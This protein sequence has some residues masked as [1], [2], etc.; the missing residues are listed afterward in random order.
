MPVALNIVGQ[1][2]GRLVA[3]KPMFVKGKGRWQCK[4]DCGNE[5]IVYVGLLRT[6]H[7]ESCGCLCKER[8]G[9]HSSVLTEKTTTVVGNLINHSGNSSSSARAASI[10]AIT[11]A[12]RFWTKVCL[13]KSGCWLWL[14]TKTRGYGMLS[15]QHRSSPVFAHRVS[16]VLH[17]GED[18]RGKLVHPEHLYIGNEADNS[19][20]AWKR[21]RAML[22]TN[23]PFGS[24]HHSAK[25]SDNDIVKIKS[26][27]SFGIE[28]L[29]EIATDYGVT[30]QAIWAIKHGR[31][32]KHVG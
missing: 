22:P 20:D 30:P 3:I 21:G 28:T 11:M 19:K 2:F 10:D 25:L 1:R 8:I 6:G 14:G 12:H 4:C 31:N 13:A 9:Y 27:L 24:S 15:T 29:K 5:V 7:T 23:A 17:T 26:R 16:Y 18:I 32:W